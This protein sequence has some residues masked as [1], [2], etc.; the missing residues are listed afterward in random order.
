MGSEMFLIP[1]GEKGCYTWKNR[2]ASFVYLCTYLLLRGITGVRSRFS[3]KDECSD[4]NGKGFG[5]GQWRGWMIEAQIHRIN[6]VPSEDRQSLVW[7]GFV[8]NTAFRQTCWRTVP[9]EMERWYMDSCW[10]RLSEI[11]SYGCVITMNIVMNVNG[12]PQLCWGCLKKSW[13]CDKERMQIEKAK[14]CATIL[15]ALL[16]DRT[17][18]RRFG[19]LSGL[20]ESY[21]LPLL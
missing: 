15:V 20:P 17:I 7:E 3:V 4:D 16:V 14:I 12:M 19:R 8:V 21:V 2:V 18:D 13:A 11:L 10:Q 5:L 1:F 9:R 6:L